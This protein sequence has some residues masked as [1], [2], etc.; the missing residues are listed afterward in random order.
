MHRGVPRR[1]ISPRILKKITHP[2]YSSCTAMT[3]RSCRT[4]MPGRWSAE[5]AAQ[6]HP[7]DLRRA[8]RTGCPP[9]R[10]MSPAPTCWSSSAVG[11]QRGCRGD[12][13]SSITVIGVARR[14]SSR[15]WAPGQ[16]PRHRQDAAVPARLP[17]PVRCW[18]W[19]CPRCA[20]RRSGQ[21]VNAS[22]WRCRPR[23]DA[24]VPFCI[25]THA[26]LP[27]IASSGAIDPD[28][29]P[30]IRPELVAVRDFL[31]TQGGSPNAGPVAAG[32]PT[33]AVLGGIAESH[34]CFSIIGRLADAFGFV[35]REGQAEN[36]ARALHRVGCPIPGFLIA[37]GPG[38]RRRR[39]STSCASSV[40]DEAGRHPT[41]RCGPPPHRVR[42]C[43]EPW[44]SFTAQV[45]GRPRNTRSATPRSITFSPPATP[46]TTSSRSTVAAATGAA[47]RAFDLGCGSLAR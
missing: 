39:P 43:P 24:A 23:A 8:S 27:R 29:P 32:L 28:E 12:S 42:P 2:R 47:M 9:R 18:R 20:G 34:W 35:L 15:C 16:D 46:R 30:S 14:C 45:R 36:G 19:P 13:R 26:E 40:L 38:Y 21:R 22:S 17:D 3:T 41:P 7:R 4:P 44:R 11:H 1:P 37:G 6:R 10:P 31:A 25:D 33:S 5:V